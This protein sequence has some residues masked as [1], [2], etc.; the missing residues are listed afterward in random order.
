MQQSF[1][2]I[3]VLTASVAHATGRN[4]VD[5]L[6]NPRADPYGFSFNYVEADDDVTRYT[7][8]IANTRRQIWDI[9]RCYAEKL[10]NWQA[11]YPFVCPATVPDMEDWKKFVPSVEL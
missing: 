11:Q 6:C 9:E 10:V 7:N 8:D 1:T 3:L 5:D 4:L 2:N